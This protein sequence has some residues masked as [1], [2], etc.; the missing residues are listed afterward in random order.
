MGIYGEIVKNADNTYTLKFKDG[1]IH[2]F[3]STGKLLWQKDRNGNQTT[4]GYNGNGHLTSVTDSF[5][6]VLTLTPNTNGTIASI[7]DSISTIATYEYY[8][9]T[10][11]LKTVTYNDGSKYKFEYMTIGGKIYLTTVKDALDNILETHAYDSNGRATTSE[12][13]GGVEKY[14][15]DYSNWT[16]A[17]PHTVVT[18]ANG[19]VTKYFFDK[20]KGR[21]LITKTE[22]SCGCGGSGS[23]T[24]KYEYDWSLNLT[25][26]TDALGRISEMTYDTN[27]NLLT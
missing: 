10:T 7:N 4:L 15:L 5:G 1:R 16:S 21:N 13:H 8:P 23:E 6:R 2:Q 12:K 25:K 11:Q 17:T 3:S 18:D 9:S 26:K 19:K 24:T 27:G 22:G 20:S 14:T